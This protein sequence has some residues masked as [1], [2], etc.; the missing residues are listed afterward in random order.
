M[1]KNPSLFLLNQVDHDYNPTWYILPVFFAPSDDLLMHLS[2]VS[3]GLY[4]C[5]HQINLSGEPTN[6]GEASFGIGSRNRC[7][8]GVGHSPH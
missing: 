2:R 8:Y 5:N 6:G 7:N 3:I 1:K 4:V